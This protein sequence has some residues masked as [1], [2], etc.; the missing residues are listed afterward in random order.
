MANEI[1]L[2]ETIEQLRDELEKLNTSS[3]SKALRFTVDSI[4]VE[5]K[6]AVTCDTSGK[7]GIKFWVINAEAGQK[8]SQGNTQTFKLRLSPVGK[9]NNNLQ[10]NDKEKE[11]NHR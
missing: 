1:G 4:D 8:Y 3:E 5:L 10:I 6:V 11:L 7:A 9:S 2:Y